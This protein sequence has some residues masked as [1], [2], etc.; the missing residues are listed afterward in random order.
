MADS[1]VTSS[2]NRSYQKPA[3]SANTPGKPKEKKYK[4]PG[5]DTK[6]RQTNL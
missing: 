5:R 4:V 6:Q 1:G 3:K 2:V